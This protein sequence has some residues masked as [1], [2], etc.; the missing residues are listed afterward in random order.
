MYPVQFLLQCLLNYEFL[1]QLISLVS[2]LFSVSCEE[3]FFSLNL[4]FSKSS[5]NKKQI[6]DLLC[7]GGR[8][9]LYRRWSP[10]PPPSLSISLTTSS[11]HLTL[12][13]TLIYWFLWISTGS[14]RVRRRFSTGGDI[15][16]FVTS[17]AAVRSWFRLLAA[18]SPKV[19]FYSG[20][21]QIQ[22][23]VRSMI[24]EL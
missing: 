16:V 19:S 14:L 17:G 2:S 15:G 9:A 1:V 23:Q 12:L 3:F 18:G 21:V 6:S 20:A 10:P 22:I 5:Q 11:P 4:S 7:F 13:P 24:A 8:W